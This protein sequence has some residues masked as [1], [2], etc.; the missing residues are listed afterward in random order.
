MFIALNIVDIVEMSSLHRI[1]ILAIFFENINDSTCL[2]VFG[3]V[4]KNVTDKMAELT[5]F[6]NGVTYELRYKV[7]DDNNWKTVQDAKS[8]HLLTNL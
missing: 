7:A 5:W 3:I 2:P 6:S 8:G 1:I 4:A